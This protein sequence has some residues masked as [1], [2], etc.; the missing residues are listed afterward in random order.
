MNYMA[1]GGIVLILIG[2]F[3]F[4]IQ[5]RKRLKPYNKYLIVVS[6]ITVF[7]IT[8][9]LFQFTFLPLLV[10]FLITSLIIEHH[11]NKAR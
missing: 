3:L 9:P 6:C 11:M 4:S 8:F 5:M 2:G 10:I 7:A 1:L